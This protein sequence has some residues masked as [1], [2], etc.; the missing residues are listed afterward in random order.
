MIQSYTAI[1]GG[2]VGVS[3]LAGAGYRF[4]TSRFARFEAEQRAQRILIE[5]IEA[6]LDVVLEY[7]KIVKE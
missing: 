4:A 3:T 6:K 7:A 1:V 2:L 5:R